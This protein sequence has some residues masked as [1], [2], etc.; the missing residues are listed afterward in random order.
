MHAIVTVEVMSRSVSSLLM[1]S[2]NDTP[3]YTQHIP[4]SYHMTSLVIQ[5][6]LT[7][8]QRLYILVLLFISYMLQ[9]LPSN[10]ILKD[11]GSGV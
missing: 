11:S 3:P 2:T 6:S 10:A 4:F 9:N 1:N 5:L 7:Q 8:E